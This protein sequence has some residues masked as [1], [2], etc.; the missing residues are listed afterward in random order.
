VH[1]L[2]EST[3]AA[4]LLVAHLNKSPSSD[5]LQ[6]LGGSVGLPAAARSV[7]LLAADPDDLDGDDGSSRVLA[8]VKS[9]VSELAPSLL[10]RIDSVTLESDAETATIREAGFSPYSGGELLVPDRAPRGSRLAE[11]IE[12]IQ[13]ELTNGEQSANEVVPASNE[14]A[15]A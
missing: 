9:N 6:R 1:K 11:A 8:H 15:A 14:V 7:L 13:R 3:G 12:F 4:V 5:P 10:L 2:A